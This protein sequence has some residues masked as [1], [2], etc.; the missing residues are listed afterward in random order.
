MNGPP[1]IDRLVAERWFANPGHW[2]AVA[3][4]T[5]DGRRL[6][7]EPYRLASRSPHETRLEQ[8]QSE[9]LLVADALAHLGYHG[10]ALQARES[11]DFRATF[12]L[13]AGGRLGT[14]GIELAQLVEPE[15]ARWHNA[16]ENLR[17]AV[18]DAVDADPALQTA[19]S[20]RYVSLNF[21]HCPKRSAERRLLR[22]ILELLRSDMLAA[23]RGGN[24]IVDGRFPTLVQHWAHVHVNASEHAYVDVTASAHTFD[25]RSLAQVAR[26]VLERKQKK[27]LGYDRSAP[28]W[29]VLSVTDQRGIF[30]ESLD[31]LE[32]FNLTIDPFER[33]VVCN[34]GRVVIWDRNGLLRAG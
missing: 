21:W 13:G 12:R 7:A 31:L 17:I 3:D 25:P 18:R 6:G 22:E 10:V 16:I 20:G 34:E 11:P 32:R 1:T 29:L 19:L 23:E 24:R 9:T 30:G 15:S 33:V 28:L 5:V 4:F 8:K 26:K 14:V 2:R 27:A